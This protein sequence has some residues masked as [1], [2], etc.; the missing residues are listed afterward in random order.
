MIENTGAPKNLVSVCLFV[1]IWADFYRRAIP[2]NRPYSTDA[3]TM[4]VI[5]CSVTNCT[6]MI[7]DPEYCIV[8]GYSGENPKEKDA[9]IVENYS[10]TFRNVPQKWGH[11]QLY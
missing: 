2:V 8:E 10:L 5:F 11:A 9:N 1:R 7:I 4:L 3:L 6:K